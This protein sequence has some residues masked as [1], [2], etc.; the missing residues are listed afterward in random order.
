VGQSV[1][2]PRESNRQS[3]ELPIKSNG[4]SIYYKQKNKKYE[5]E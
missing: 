3:V 5:Y 1:E 4:R 2:L